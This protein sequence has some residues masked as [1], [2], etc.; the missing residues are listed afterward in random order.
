MGS[1]LAD[2]IEAQLFERGCGV[3][4]VDSVLKGVELRLK[5]FGEC[6]RKKRE[7]EKNFEKRHWG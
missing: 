5:G 4:E 3:L 1:N 6:R 7:E 2:A